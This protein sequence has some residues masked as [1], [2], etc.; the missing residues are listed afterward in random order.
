M[1]IWHVGELHV[2]LWGGK[3]YVYVVNANW[4]NILTLE[5]NWRRNWK[6]MVNRLI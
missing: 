1:T 3:S 2:G 5:L 4:R 6:A